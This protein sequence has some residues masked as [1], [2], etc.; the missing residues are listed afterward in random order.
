MFFIL[1]NLV[2]SENRTFLIETLGDQ[3]YHGLYG[4]LSTAAMGSVGY[5]YVRKISTSPSPSILGISQLVSHWGVRGRVASWA[6]TSSGL[7]MA[8][9]ALPKLQI[10][11]EYYNSSQDQQ[12][13]TTTTYAEGPVAPPMNNSSSST[14]GSWKVC[15]P[16]DFTDSK[17]KD[18][19]SSSGE[20]LE[21]HGLER[22][23]RHPGL[24]SFAC[25]G[26]GHACLVPLMPQKIWWS[27]PFWVALVGGSHT[28]SRYR[29]GI[30]GTL[31]PEYDRQTSNFPFYAMLTGKQQDGNVLASVQAL[32]KE[33][34]PWNAFLA[35][36]TATLWV[37][38]RG[39]SGTRGIRAATSAT[40]IIK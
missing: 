20:V 32:T 25:L 1:E 28:D 23:S 24:W 3:G 19:N 2:L 22:I 29:R 9:Q 15:C 35:T 8:S 37:I 16:F 30:G 4:T 18:N 34:K 40:G 11:L 7:I 10:P 17:I 21:V 39:K 36:T 12:Q 14:G 33:L 6:F 26:L 13:H 27:M 38:S 31:D 5:A